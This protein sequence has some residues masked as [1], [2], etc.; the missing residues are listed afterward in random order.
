MVEIN[1]YNIN[2][3][4]GK[5]ISQLD[6]LSN[7]T[8][9]TS[10]PV[11]LSGDTYHVQYSSITNNLIEQGFNNGIKLLSK[12]TVNLNYPLEPIGIS[13]ILYCPN[14]L[15]VLPNFELGE[16]IINQFGVTGEVVSNYDTVNGGTI[17][18]INVSGGSFNV[19]ENITGLTSNYT[20]LIYELTDTASLQPITL[21]GG[22]NFIIQSSFI[23]N[24]S[25]PTFNC[26]GGIV[27][28]SN[29]TTLTQCYNMVNTLTTP[30]SYV[31]SYCGEPQG[32]SVFYTSSNQVYLK[33]STIEGSD[34][35]ADLYIY[36]YILN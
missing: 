31:L 12:Q 21:T 13:S 22:T 14:G 29:D 24:P 10:I 6:L 7:I 36:G 3:I 25:A 19:G 16:T 33:L 20:S 2:M 32:T 23:T 35:T 18:V 4:T 5:T 34:V 17:D 1:T 15:C 26:V 8:D 30:N 28:S 11:E 27:N 9:N